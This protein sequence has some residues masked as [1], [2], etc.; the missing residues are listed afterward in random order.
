MGGHYLACSRNLCRLTHVKKNQQCQELLFN[1]STWYIKQK[2]FAPHPVS[3][4]AKSKKTRDWQSG[5]IPHVLTLIFADHLNLFLGASW[6]ARLK[7]LS[8]GC[9]SLVQQHDD[10]HWREEVTKH[11]KEETEKKDKEKKDKEDVVKKRSKEKVPKT[12][13][14][15]GHCWQLRKEDLDA[16]KQVWSIE[17]RAGLFDTSSV[18]IPVEY[19]C[20]AC[21]RPSFPVFVNVCS[22]TNT[23]AE[24]ADYLTQKRC[25]D[26]NA[27]GRTIVLGL[28]PHFIACMA[29]GD[30]LFWRIRPYP[31]VPP[32]DNNNSCVSTRNPSKVFKKKEISPAATYQAGE[33]CSKCGE[34]I[35]MPKPWHHTSL[36]VPSF[37]I[38]P[39]LEPT[40]E[41]VVCWSSKSTL[42]LV[43]GPFVFACD[44]T[45][46]MQLLGG[47]DGDTVVVVRA[48][49]CHVVAPPWITSMVQLTPVCCVTPD[50]PALL[51][52]TLRET[53]GAM[54]WARPDVVAVPQNRTLPGGTLHNLILEQPGPVCVGGVALC[55]LGQSV[56]GFEDTFWGS[57]RVIEHYSAM[58]GFPNVKTFAVGAIH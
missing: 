12:A 6:S 22:G 30:G 45:P 11:M 26:I 2:S 20:G 9:R 17:R 46:G 18:R 15:Y 47:E 43:D 19:S 37:H 13:S 32:T 34:S 38:F 58:S 40:G 10:T 57:S 3:L 56:P 49:V 48:V 8:L 25:Y 4:M 29:G 36:V 53:G 16:C 33:P 42:Q 41:E 21:G 35:D 14:L 50:H 39:I 51:P 54:H 52:A 28:A 1:Y 7:V 24:V 31:G 44:V 55:T 5:V 27:A 23:L